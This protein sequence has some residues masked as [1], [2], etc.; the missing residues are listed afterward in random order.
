MKTFVEK[1]HL[2]QTII[3]YASIL[4][5][6]VFICLWL[7]SGWQAAKDELIIIAVTLISIGCCYIWFRVLSP[8][9]IDKENIERINILKKEIDGIKAKE[10]ISSN[11]FIKTFDTIQFIPVNVNLYQKKLYIVIPDLQIVNRDNTDR[12]ISIE[13]RIKAQQSGCIVIHA[14][15]QNVTKIDSMLISQNKTTQFLGQSINI[16]RKSSV[17]GYMA[18][19][20]THLDV[21]EAIIKL[22]W[23]HIEKNKNLSFEIHE[24]TTN[25]KEILTL[26]ELIVGKEMQLLSRR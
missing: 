20:V 21:D 2:N 3:I 15:S 24:N 14:M 18:F 10:K 26:G 5:V 19:L 23:E 12:V 22:S 6:V 17:S 13:L 7:F 4:A 9:Q 8:M 1:L 16:G 25:T 11:I